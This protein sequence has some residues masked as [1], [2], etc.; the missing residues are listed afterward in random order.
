MADKISV[1]I[2][3]RNSAKYLAECL[4]ALND[5]D[6]VLILDNGST[7]E[8]MAIARQFCNVLVHEHPFIGFGPMK[9]LALDLAK[10]DWIL[11]VD[12]DE[13][14]TPELAREILSLK[15][16]P[17]C[18]YAVERENHYHG[19]LIR[20]CGWDNDRVHRLFNRRRT[21][22]DERLIHEGLAGSGSMP[23]ELLRGRL[24]HYPYDEASQL[25]AKMQQYST[26]WAEDNL[27][28]KRSTPFG[29]FLNGAL[30]F[31]KS[32]V[33]QKGWCYGYEGLLISVSNANG[34]FYK[35]IKLYEAGRTD[36]V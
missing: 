33:M 25:V 7:D 3:T 26:L 2:L 24:K 29:A 11:S 8:T 14:V 27:G 6:E 30:T 21:R 31:F 1:T 32:Y 20:G 35:Y 9:N 17:S 4:S 13:I 22:F 23:V 18:L 10:N 15:L 34:A 16:K 36:E 19:K 12:S 5:F 28:K